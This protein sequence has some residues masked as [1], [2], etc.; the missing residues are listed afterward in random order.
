MFPPQVFEIFRVY[1]VFRGLCV[2]LNNWRGSLGSLVKLMEL[3]CSELSLTNTLPLKR[4][5]LNTKPPFFIGFETRSYGLN[6]I[7]N[8]PFFYK[9]NHRHIFLNSIIISDF[10]IW[11][12]VILKL[13]KKCLLKFITLKFTNQCLQKK[14][15]VKM[16][17]LDNYLDVEHLFSHFM[18]YGNYELSWIY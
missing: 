1:I 3:N 14:S 4:K 10:R 15:I 9:P 12:A 13:K 8:I 5:K 2:N 7:M 6:G 17:N 18:S 16:Y 11:S